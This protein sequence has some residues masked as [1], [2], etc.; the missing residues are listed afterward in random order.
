MAHSKTTKYYSNNALEEETALK[1][2]VKVDFYWVLF[3]LFVSD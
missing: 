2:E 1:E 3:Y